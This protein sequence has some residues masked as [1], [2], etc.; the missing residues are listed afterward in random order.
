MKYSD[1]GR[2]VRLKYDAKH[3]KGAW[4]KLPKEKKATIL[5]D[6]LRKKAA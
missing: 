2:E 3:G 6:Y 4:V 5:N 1:L